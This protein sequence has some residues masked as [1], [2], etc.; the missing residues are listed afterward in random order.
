M[1]F[2]EE[3][4]PSASLMHPCLPC[5]DGCLEQ[6]Q[7]SR[8]RRGAGMDASKHVEMLEGHKYIALRGDRFLHLGIED[9]LKLLVRAI[10]LDV[11]EGFFQRTFVDLSD[12]EQTMA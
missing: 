5:R 11:L 1:V 9:H 8:S 12:C 3:T 4:V 6:R 7:V 10:L 2:Q